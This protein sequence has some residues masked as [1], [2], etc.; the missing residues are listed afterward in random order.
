MYYESRYVNEAASSSIWTV[1]SARARSGRGCTC[2]GE[3][4]GRNAGFTDV[5]CERQLI[6][7]TLAVFSERF[8]KA[9][10]LAGPWNTS[11]RSE[12]DLQNIYQLWL[13][14]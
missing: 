4:G 1:R 3:D 9:E 7:E 5:S 2:A 13:L 6:Y 11:V 12:E 10:R 8:L 14:S